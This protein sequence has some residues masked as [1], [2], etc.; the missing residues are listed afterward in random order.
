[1]PKPTIELP[2]I[3]DGWLD[4]PAATPPHAPDY[5]PRL[6]PGFGQ[7]GVLGSWQPK[8]WCLED[9]GLH[10]LLGPEAVADID[11]TSDGDAPAGG[12]SSLQNDSSGQAGN[13][14]QPNDRTHA[15]PSWIQLPQPGDLEAGE[16]GSG[17]YTYGT[18]PSHRPGTGPNY[19][20]GEPRTMEVIG[21]VAD[22]LARGSQYTPFGIG[23][24]SLSDGARSKDH[25]GHQDGRGI[26][27]RPARLDGAQLPVTY[28]DPQYDRAAT[29]R[30]VDAFR[31]TGQA[32]AIYFND[33][34][35]RG[36]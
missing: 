32:G 15:K 24:V 9:S 36:V 2:D 28:N 17:Y 25:Q 29:Q 34:Q 13:T 4:N 14:T 33:P 11:W 19:Q 30:L 26:D 12:Q 5:T 27:V 35:L 8:E 6:D 7:A 10:F 22:R 20:W 3:P 21:S 23:N 31:A 1:M 18:D 16:H